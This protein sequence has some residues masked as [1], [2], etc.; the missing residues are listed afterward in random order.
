MSIWIEASA[1]L[2]RM[3]ENGQTKKVTEQYLVEALSMSEAEAIVTEKLTPFAGDNL[4]VSATRESNV[5]EIFY[6]E[7]CDKWYRVKSAFVTVDEKSG[8]EKKAMFHYMVQATDFQNA[9]NN[10]LDGMKGIMSD[11]E[12]I[13]IAETKILEVF[14]EK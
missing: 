3:M 5:S 1:R 8:K 9:L 13:S 7:H 10:F 11:Y 2:H 12:I 4:T 14:K 6:N